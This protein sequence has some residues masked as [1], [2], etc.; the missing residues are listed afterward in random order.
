MEKLKEIWTEHK[1]KILI[2]I[3]VIVAFFAYR[4]FSNKNA[5]R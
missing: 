1:T 4:K 2:G 5:R 3:G